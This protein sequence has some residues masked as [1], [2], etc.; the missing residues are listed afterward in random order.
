VQE[1][2]HEQDTLE[3]G[4]QHVDLD[5]SSSSIADDVASPPPPT[6]PAAKAQQEEV[7]LEEHKGLD[8]GGEY[9]LSSASQDH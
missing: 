7:Q 1:H 4:Q 2:T 9:N 3:R 5:I 6:E 8:S